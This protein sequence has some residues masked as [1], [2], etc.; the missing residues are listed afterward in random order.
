MSPCDLA[1]CPPTTTNGFSR[2]ELTEEENQWLKCGDTRTPSHDSWGA[3]FYLLLIGWLRAAEQVSSPVGCNLPP[4]PGVLFRMRNHGAWLQNSN[5]HKYVFLYF[6][7]ST[8]EMRR[9]CHFN[10]L[11]GL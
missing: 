4:F 5:L 9:K 3:Q 11:S 1:K 8:R 7:S 10:V 6:I 2:N